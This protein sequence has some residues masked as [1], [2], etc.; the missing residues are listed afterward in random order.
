MKVG[1]LKK[2]LE[3]YEIWLRDRFN[4]KP[5]ATTQLSQIK[6]LYLMKQL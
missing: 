1:T 5:W 3:E 2:I 4:F 6:T